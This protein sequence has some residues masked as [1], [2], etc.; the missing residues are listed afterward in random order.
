MQSLFMVFCDSCSL[1][2]NYIFS[3]S[4]LA[5]MRSLVEGNVIYNT[6]NSTAASIMPL[7]ELTLITSIAT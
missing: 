2:K 1:G 3:S 4:G 6:K 5:L 7:L